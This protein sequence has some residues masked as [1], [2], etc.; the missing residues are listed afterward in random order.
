MSR[1][2]RSFLPLPLTPSTNLP[3]HTSTDVSEENLNSFAH[4]DVFF[5]LGNLHKSGVVSNAQS[6]SDSN[7]FH[8]TALMAL[9]W[10]WAA[11]R[12]S[13]VIVCL[14][15]ACEYVWNPQRWFDSYHWAVIRGSVLQEMTLWAPERIP[16]S[17]W[18]ICL[19]EW[20]CMP[21][22][23][24]AEQPEGWLTGFASTQFRLLLNWLCLMKSN[25]LA[26]VSTNPGTS[27]TRTS[28]G[29]N[30]APA[31]RLVFNSD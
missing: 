24:A 4:T 13:L 23:R 30:G 17:S 1:S 15:C 14:F 19:Y 22:G 9:L 28:L 29:L 21:S 31:C 16:I 11:L 25:R 3:K 20:Y 26:A 6:F 5:A 18:I 27:E 8:F 2:L 12:D 10:L 7:A